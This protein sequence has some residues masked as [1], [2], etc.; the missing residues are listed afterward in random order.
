MEKGITLTE[1]FNSLSDKA[2]NLGLFMEKVEKKCKEH[3]T[4]E[5]Y[6]EYTDRI[7]A[8]GKAKM[9]AVAHELYNDLDSVKWTSERVYVDP[10]MDMY[11]IVSEGMWAVMHPMN[12][13]LTKEGFQ[14]ISEMTYSYMG[15]IYEE[16][17]VL[18][19]VDEKVL[20]LRIYAW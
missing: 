13:Y 16:N 3:L 5:E 20:S 7:K 8:E 6:Q 11:E 14:E 10:S 4:A 9:A 2:V 12:H 17:N 19:G 1:Y 18:Q 15:D